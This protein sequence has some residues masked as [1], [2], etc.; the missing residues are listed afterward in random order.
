MTRTQ[1]TLV[2]LIA[3]LLVAFVAMLLLLRPSAVM[4]EQPA[5]NQN[6]PVNQPSGGLPTGTGN[7]FDTEV[8]NANAAPAEPAA[9]PSASANLQRVGAAFAERY[10]SF[11][12]TG[13]F[14]NLTDLAPFMTQS[15]AASTAGYVEGQRSRPRSGEYSGTTTRALS[16]TVDAIDESAGSAEVTV[17]TQ[18]RSQGATIASEQVYYQKLK[19]TFSRAGD[20]WLVAAATW[21][22]R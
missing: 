15:F 3:V 19:L 10:G 21:E 20:S 6:Q 8:S 4:P 1:K 2:V 9:P 16:V 7:G 22:P 5:A 11:S 12:S 18:R 14:E 17:N 13:N